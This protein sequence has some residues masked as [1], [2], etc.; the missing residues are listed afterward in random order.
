M[1]NVVRVQQYIAQKKI[2]Q[3][4]NKISFN[5]H[6]ERT[7]SERLLRE[8]ITKLFAM[9]NKKKHCIPSNKISKM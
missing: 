7:R 8:K 4:R 9:Q 2:L 5:M 3:N 1:A 6:C